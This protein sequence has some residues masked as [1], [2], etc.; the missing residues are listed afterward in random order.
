MPDP[1]LGEV[2]PGVTGAYVT[3]EKWLGYVLAEE[4]HGTDWLRVFGQVGPERLWAAVVEA[5]RISP[6]IEIRDLDDLGVTCR[7]LITLT[8]DD[9]TAPVR[10]VWHYDSDQAPPRLVTAFPVS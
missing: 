2:L 4:G 10:T 7:V 9:R 5:V 8:I 3:E 6:V 1:E